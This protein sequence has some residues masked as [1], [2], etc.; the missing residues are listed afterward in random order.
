[1]TARELIAF[2]K[3]MYNRGVSWVSIFLGFASIATMVKV[4]EDFFLIHLGMPI[5]TVLA[6]II[7]CYI[8]G[9][10]II[11][12]FDYKWGM[13]KEESDIGY[14]AAPLA[15]KQREEVSEILRLLKK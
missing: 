5:S 10:G 2:G 15:D 6:I 8:V 4:Y 14:R 11:G 7:P 3:M 13:M 1:M 12:Y 9:C